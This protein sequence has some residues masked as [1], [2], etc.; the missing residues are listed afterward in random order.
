MVKPCR[1]GIGGRAASCGTSIHL[2]QAPY[3]PDIGYGQTSSYGAVATAAGHPRAARA[4]GS[5]CANN[6]LPVVVPC[7]R[8]IRGDGSPGP[9]L[10]GPAA[11]KLLLNL[12]ASA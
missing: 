12:E 7:H 5:A 6:P 2:D 8:V 11:K 4:V 10:G 9:Y 3:L 1:P